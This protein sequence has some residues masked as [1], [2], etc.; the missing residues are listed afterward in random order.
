MIT[1]SWRSSWAPGKAPTRSCPPRT[2]PCTGSCPRSGST[3]TATRTPASRVIRGEGKGFSAGGDLG[4]VEDM[5][6]DFDVRSRVWREARDLVYNIIN[7]SKP[8]VSAM[9]GPG[10]RRRPGRRAA[11]RHLDRHEERPH[12]RR[13]HAARC[14]R[15]RPLRRSSG[16]CLCGMAKAKYYLLLCEAVSGEEAERIGLVSL[17]V[18]DDEL[19]PKAFEVA[20]KLAQRVA[21]GDSLDEVR[22]E[23]LAAHGG[24]D[25]RRVAGAGVHGLL[26]PRRAGGNSSAARAPS[27]CIRSALPF[28]S[29]ARLHAGT[30]D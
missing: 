29:R 4:L 7:C 27:P 13:P 19:L 8:V 2:T 22:A 14:R 17:A 15:R 12:H 23:Q 28:L 26:G 11:G 16:R 30:T 1:A 5:A 10:G 9:H 3:S 24:A 18:E 21:V 25:L 20:G 6:R